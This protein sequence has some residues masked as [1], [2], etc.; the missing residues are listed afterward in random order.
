MEA[1]G[2]PTMRLSTTTEGRWML[3]RASLNTT[4]TGK[5]GRTRTRS[6][7]TRMATARTCRGFC[8]GQRN[9]GW[10]WRPA[11]SGS[12]ARSSTMQ[13]TPPTSGRCQASSGPCAPLRWHLGMSSRGTALWVPTSFLAAGEKTTPPPGFSKTPWQLGSRRVWYLSSRWETQA[14][15]AV[16]SSALQIMP[17]CSLWGPPISMTKWL[18]SPLGGLVRTA[19]K[20]PF[21]TT[22]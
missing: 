16:Q 9:R 12:Q 5:T 1:F 20:A 14:R 3:T 15:I 11:L 6:L 2:T 22:L 21:H 17:V 10:G 13:D 4:T 7:S 18:N 19:L 8:P